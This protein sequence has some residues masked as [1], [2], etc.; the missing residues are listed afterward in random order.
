VNQLNESRTPVQ[1][2]SGPNIRPLN[3]RRL[4][5]VNL[6]TGTLRKNIFATFLKE[7]SACN[8]QKNRIQITLI[9]I[10]APQK[11]G[12]RKSPVTLRLS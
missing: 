2:T 3:Y 11:N 9:F 1:S 6:P 7:K 12:S 4:R 5:S 10:L 8:T